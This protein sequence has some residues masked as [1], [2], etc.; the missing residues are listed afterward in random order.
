MNPF[1]REKKE[2]KVTNSEYEPFFKGKKGGA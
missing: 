1:S 2:E